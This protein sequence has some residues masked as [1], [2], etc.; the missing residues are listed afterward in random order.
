LRLEQVAGPYAGPADGPVWDGEA[1]LFTLVA[2]SRIMRYHPGTGR[3]VEHRKY[4]NNTVGLALAGANVLYGCESAGCRIVRFNADGSTS[5]LADRL[6]GR[7]HNQPDDLVVDSDGRIWFTD[8]LPATFVLAPP[9]DHSSVLRLERDPDG[10]WRLQRMTFDTAFPTAIALSSDGRT[11]YVG[12]NADAAELRAYPVGG[13]GTLGSPAVLRSFDA[14]DG[15]QGMCIDPDGNIVACVGAGVGV[16]SPSGEQLDRHEIGEARTTNC[17]FG[18]SGLATLYVTTDD[19][20]LYAL[21]DTG[22]QGG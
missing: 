17:A 3:V 5:M 16:F 13:D 11:L 15:V 4:T 10:R 18:G 22:R 20:S 12:E 21:S 19:G 9:V 6:D 7:L 2:E 8:P 1:L 14:G